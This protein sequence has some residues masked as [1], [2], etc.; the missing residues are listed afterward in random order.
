MIYK[1]YFQNFLEMGLQYVGF[2]AKE[3]KTHSMEGFSETLG[4]NLHYEEAMQGFSICIVP[5]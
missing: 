2:G 5:E 4:I 3:L 1:D